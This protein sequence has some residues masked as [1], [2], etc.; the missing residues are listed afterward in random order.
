MAGV[1]SIEGSDVY[2][3]LDVLGLLDAFLDLSLILQVG[4][5][6]EGFVQSWTEVVLEA[7]RVLCLI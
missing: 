5:C 1:Y 7:E 6:F 3:F 4:L 2:T